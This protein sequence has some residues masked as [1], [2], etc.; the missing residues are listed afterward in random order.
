[1]H[2]PDASRFAPPPAHFAGQ[3]WGLGLILAIFVVLATLYNV[4]VPILEAPDE[5]LHYLAARHLA[6][7]GGLQPMV[8]RQSAEG[9]RLPP[10]FHGLGALLTLGVDT[11]EGPALQANPYANVCRPETPGNKNLVMHPE[12]EGWPYRGV[13]LAV[14]LLRLLS[15]LCAAG[16]VALAFLA[17]REALPNHPGVALGAAALFAF[18]P[19][20]VFVG[21]SATSAAAGVLF[22]TAALYLALRVANGRALGGPRAAALLGLLVGLGLL[23]HVSLLVA[24]ALPPLAYGA[25]LWRQ[26]RAEREDPAADPLHGLLVPTAV[27]WGVALAIGGWWYILNA[28]QGI[29]PLGGGLLGGDVVRA[30]STLRET[31]LSPWETVEAMARSLRSYW[32]VFG[33]MNIPADEAYYVFVQ[34]L[35]VLGVAGLGLGAMWALWNRGDTAGQP[36]HTVGL[37]AAWALLQGVVYALYARAATCPQGRLLFPAGAGISLLLGLGIYVLAPRRYGGALVGALAAV[38]LVVAAAAP[39]RYIAPAYAAPARVALEEAPATMSDLAIRF[40]EDVFLLGHHMERRSV[41]TGD[42]LRVRLYWLATG[43]MDED[44]TVSLRVYGRDEAVIGSMDSYPGMGSYP[45]SRWVPGEVIVDDYEIPIAEDALAPTAASVR[46]GVYRRQGMEHLAAL[47]AAGNDVGTG[48]AIARVRVA[49]GRPT[50]SAPAQPLD[51]RFGE[52]IALEGYDLS[53]ADTEDGDMLAVTLHWRRHGPV[54]GDWTV[55]VHLQDEVGNLIA[56]DD[57]QPVR[58]DYPTSYWDLEEAVADEHLLVLPDDLPAGRYNLHVG[59][60]TLG[61]EERLPVTGRES[62][63]DYA[64]IGTLTIEGP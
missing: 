27:A 50:V 2:G 13:P 58:G 6:E 4:R 19:Q 25:R 12:A 7:G 24:L 63:G 11:G 57:A 22:G 9:V 35:T 43:A 8:T 32:G 59:L 44:L 20:F 15:T 18:N 17:A 36:W 61:S 23:A 41:K 34:L 10:L 16:A 51:L 64:A 33:W 47:D 62:R 14:H 52:A 60:Y 56:Q 28:A 1:M 3:R 55:F 49:A 31:S 38:L 42:V 40:S 46:V 21:A 5:A 29:D 54:A 30:A 45:T 48:P 37:V 26:R 53:R 39:F